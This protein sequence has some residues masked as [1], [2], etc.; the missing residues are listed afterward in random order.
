[1]LKIVYK[2]KNE[3]KKDHFPFSTPMSEQ[4][5]EKYPYMEGK[6]RRGS[7]HQLTQTG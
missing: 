7:F 3:A 2:S 6:I 1:M 4:S 5:Q